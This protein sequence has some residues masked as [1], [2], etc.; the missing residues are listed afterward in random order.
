ML[1][2]GFAGLAHCVPVLET[3]SGAIDWRKRHWKR[4]APVDCEGKVDPNHRH[5]RLP[6][7]LPLRSPRLLRVWWMLC[8][9]PMPPFPIVAMLLEAAAPEAADARV[10]LDRRERCPLEC[11]VGFLLAVQSAERSHA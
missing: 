2:Q 1:E 6:N 3:Q 7:P 8:P 9:Y 4:I 11:S 10:V 5:L